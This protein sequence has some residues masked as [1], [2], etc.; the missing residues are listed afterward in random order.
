VG[1][2]PGDIR[3][4]DRFEFVGITDEVEGFSDQNLQ[5]WDEK[6]LHRVGSAPGVLDPV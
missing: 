3:E 2:S 1:G 5:F 6:P 4:V